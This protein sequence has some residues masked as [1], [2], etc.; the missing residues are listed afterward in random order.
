MKPVSSKETYLVLF[1]P[2]KCRKRAQRRKTRTQRI[3]EIITEQ[4]FRA[5][6]SIPLSA[7]S[8]THDYLWHRTH[9]PSRSA[10]TRRANSRTIP[11]NAKQLA[12]IPAELE[13]HDHNDSA[14]GSV[15]SVYLIDACP[16]NESQL[17][18]RGRLDLLYYY[19]TIKRRYSAA[20]I[21]AE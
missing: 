8:P 7:S 6:C 9:F 4:R 14:N 3:P 18:G 2:L 5:L 15:R 21:S 17:K 20:P 12:F 19:L 10:N 11:E 1:Q 13:K 16:T